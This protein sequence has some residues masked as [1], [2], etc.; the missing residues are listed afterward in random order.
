MDLAHVSRDPDPDPDPSRPPKLS[1]TSL[2]NRGVA[3]RREFVRRV[4]FHRRVGQS[5]RLLPRRARVVL[6]C[7]LV[8]ALYE[9]ATVVLRPF[10]T[11]RPAP[12]DESDGRAPGPTPSAANFPF[13][14]TQVRR[15]SARLVY[16]SGASQEIFRPPPPTSSRAARRDEYVHELWDEGEVTSVE[17]PLGATLHFEGEQKGTIEHGRGEKCNANSCKGIDRVSLEQ[18]VLVGL[19]QM[20]HSGP[21]HPPLLTRL[22]IT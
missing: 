4:P 11:V 19:R 17:V 18:D 9:L 21:S 1:P 16:S 13:A 7:A 20:R 15:T 8:L 6:V 3:K 2:A 12:G 5:Y 22:F 14:P 10:L